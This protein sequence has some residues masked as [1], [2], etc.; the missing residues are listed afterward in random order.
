MTD[1]AIPRAVARIWAQSLTFETAARELRVAPAIVREAS[2][3][4]GRITY[5][6]AF[7]AAVAFHRAKID[8]EALDA[9]LRPAR[10]GLPPGLYGTPLHLRRLRTDAARAAQGLVDV[11]DRRLARLAAVAAA[12]TPDGSDDARRIARL[13]GDFEALAAAL[14]KRN[15]RAV[16]GLAPKEPRQ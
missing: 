16:R 11:I 13:T 6:D 10:R 15:A 2:D 12:Q 7:A 3:A 4:D 14:H 5:G 9:A 1:P 8:P